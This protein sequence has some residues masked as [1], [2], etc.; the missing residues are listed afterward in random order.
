MLRNFTEHPVITI[1]NHNQQA[2][3]PRFYV[4]QVADPRGEPGMCVSKVLPW[5]KSYEPEVEGHRVMA[6]SFA[7]RYEAMQARGE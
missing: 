1:M 5:D 2:T 7:T 6:G 4:E 3:L